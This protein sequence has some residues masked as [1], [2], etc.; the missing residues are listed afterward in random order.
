MYFGWKHSDQTQYTN[1]LK[2]LEYDGIEFNIAASDALHVRQQYNVAVNSHSSTHT[3]Y[4][5]TTKPY[6]SLSENVNFARTDGSV[7]NEKKV[8]ALDSRMMKVP[9]EKGSPGTVNT[10]YVILPKEMK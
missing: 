8:K 2:P 6:T 7:Y 4:L 9:Y 3:W 10:D 1:I 5:P